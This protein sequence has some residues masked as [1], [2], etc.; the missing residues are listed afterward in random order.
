M[1]NLT[2]AAWRR[3]NPI[4][5]HLAASE[6][7]SVEVLADTIG[8][9][10]AIIYMWMNGSHEPRVRH[11]R[12]IQEVTGITVQVWTDWYDQKPTKKG[13]SRGAS[14]SNVSNNR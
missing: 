7:H 12:K 8:V 4:R 13:K 11:L 6:D 5:L 10:R 9:S 14:Q 2:P 3:S 1:A